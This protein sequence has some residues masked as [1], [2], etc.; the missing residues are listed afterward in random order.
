MKKEHITAPN[1]ACAQKCI[2]EGA[3]LVF[4]DEKDRR[5]LR[6]TN[7]ELRRRVWRV[8]TSSCPAPSMRTAKTHDGWLGQGAQKNTFQ[9]L[10]AQ[11]RI[12]R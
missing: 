10:A 1:R 11:E 7:P 12:R 5:H 3:G 8:T 9:L 4:L 2:S 6:V